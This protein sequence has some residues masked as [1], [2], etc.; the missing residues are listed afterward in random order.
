MPSQ[1]SHGKSVSTC[2]SQRRIL[3]SRTVLCHS[4]QA[5]VSSPNRQRIPRTMVLTANS[6]TLVVF[7]NTYNPKAPK[8]SMWQFIVFWNEFKSGV[9]SAGAFS[10]LVSTQRSNTR[11]ACACI[12]VKNECSKDSAT[13]KESAMALRAIEFVHR[14]SV[15]G[16]VWMSCYH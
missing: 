13:V 6:F 11:Q 12:S 3:R 10:R 15:V 5:G 14:H 7:T 4:P 16:A 2:L 8:R 1:A 9:S